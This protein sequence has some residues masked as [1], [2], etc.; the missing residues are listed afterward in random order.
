MRL[1]SPPMPLALSRLHP[2]AP[3]LPLQLS[4]MVRLVPSPDWFVGV[5]SVDLCDVDRWKDNVTLELFPY[6]AGTDS[7]FTF[8]SP[9][10]QTIPQDK[11]TQVGLPETR[12]ATS[13][14]PEPEIPN[15][16]NLFPSTDHFLLPQ[17]P[18]QLLL[19]PAPEAP[20]THRQGDAD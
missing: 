18:C 11:I 5:E 10:F 19:L 1:T 20:A 2:H 13:I 15:P 16:T 12:P 8:S 3:P 6:D 17:P 9:N 7:G 14:G 4:F